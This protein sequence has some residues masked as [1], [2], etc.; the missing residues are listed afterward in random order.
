M[1]PGTVPVLVEGREKNTGKYLGFG[2]IAEAGIGTHCSCAHSQSLLLSADYRS[3]YFAARGGCGSIIT[4]LKG[5]TSRINGGVRNLE[6]V[7]ANIDYGQKPARYRRRA[8]GYQ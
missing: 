2:G 6:A 3:Y 1:A 7:D 8:A 5:S 4:M